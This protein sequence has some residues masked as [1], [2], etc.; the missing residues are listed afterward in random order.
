MLSNEPWIR[1]VAARKAEIARRYRTK[2]DRAKP[3]SV[4][5]LRIAELHRLF[6][7]RYGFVLPNSPDGREA[8]R[9]VAHHLGHCSLPK[10]RIAHWLELNT[11]WMPESDIRTMVETITAKPLRWRALTLANRLRITPDERKQLGI[12]TIRAMGATKAE[13]NHGRREKGRA[14]DQQRRR[15]KGAKPRAQYEGESISRTKKWNELGIS[16]ATWYRHGKPN[17]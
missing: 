17:P 7:S 5:A 16:R 1:K 13:M 2:N 14:R 6:R 4:T 12:S 10:R 3:F 11:P 8:A 15:A 9:I